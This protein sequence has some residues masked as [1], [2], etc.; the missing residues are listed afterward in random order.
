MAMQTRL[1][2]VTQGLSARQRITLII[3]ARHEG[4]DPDPELGRVS[5]PQQSKA[6]NRYVAL[7]YVINRELGAICHTVS[8]WSEFLDYLR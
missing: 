5:D 3:Q 6:F 1:Q 8:G 4:R 7:L 2:K